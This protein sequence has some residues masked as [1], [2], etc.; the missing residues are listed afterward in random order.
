MKTLEFSKLLPAGLGLSHFGDPEKAGM[1]ATSRNSWWL[2]CCPGS[3][4][5]SG[6]SWT[7]QD[8]GRS[9]DKV[10]LGKNYFLRSW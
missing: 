4:E 8:A 3:V 9:E 1:L 5:L 10:K 7:W 2:H 6:A